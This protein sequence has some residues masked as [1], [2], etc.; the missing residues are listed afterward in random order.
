MSVLHIIIDIWLPHIALSTTFSFIENMYSC[1]DHCIW[2]RCPDVQHRNLSC[3][4][5]F[6]DSSILLKISMQR[7]YTS[8]KWQA[9]GVD[10]HAYPQIVQNPPQDDELN[11]FVTERNHFSSYWQYIIPGSLLDPNLAARHSGI[12]RGPHQ[13]AWG[14]PEVCA[15]SVSA[16]ARRHRRTISASASFEASTVLAV[17]RFESGDWVFSKKKTHLSSLI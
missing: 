14:G 7:T 10:V 12:L 6:A 13:R 4:L 17:E 3:L 8:S 9:N 11:D 5:L 16:K 2:L 15:E 1:D